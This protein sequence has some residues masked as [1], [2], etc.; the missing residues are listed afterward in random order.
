MTRINQRIDFDSSI[1]TNHVGKPKRRKE[2]TKPPKNAKEAKAII[3]ELYDRSPLLALTSSMSA[4]TGLRYSD[5]SWL[6]F[7]D[8]KDE[9]GNWKSS[10]DVCQ[11]KTYRMRIAR[12]KDNATSAYNASLV[13][14]FLNEDIKEI[15]E[16]CRFLSCSKEFLFANKRSRV[17]DEQGR[18]IDRPMDIRSANYHHENVRKKLK[19][20]Y[21]LNTHSWRKYFAKKLIQKGE[22]LEKVRDSLGQTSLN[23]TNHYLTTFDE[24]LAPIIEKMRLFE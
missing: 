12:N 19:L 17:V 6:K 7:S 15:V 4:L 14:I 22:T 24:E 2:A 16:E 10:F 9:F 1:T 3:D 21:S 13:R 11:Q 8:F 5:A 18:T 20:N 23:S